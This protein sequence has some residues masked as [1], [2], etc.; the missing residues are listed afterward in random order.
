MFGLHMK[1]ANYNDCY[2]QINNQWVMI[3][4]Q[5][6]GPVCNVNN[7]ELDPDFPERIALKNYSEN[8]GLLSELERLGI[9]QDTGMTIKSGYVDYN[10]CTFDIDKAF[11]L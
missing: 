7:P 10:I 4:S 1:F 5:T 6:E 3:M 9:V 11:E 2:F 8:E